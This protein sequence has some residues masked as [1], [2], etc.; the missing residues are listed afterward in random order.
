MAG[1]KARGNLAR[2]TRNARSFERGAVRREERNQAQEL[3]HQ[4]NKATKAAGGLTPWQV[5]KQL[6][7]ERR[8]AERLAEE[9]SQ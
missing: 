3:A 7:K 8:A 9:Q 1:K 2:K 6:R 4:E 5:S